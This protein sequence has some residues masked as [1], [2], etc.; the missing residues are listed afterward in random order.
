MNQ[1]RRMTDREMEETRYKIVSSL[2][3]WPGAS[4]NSLPDVMGLVQV[5]GHHVEIGSL[6]GASALAAAWSKSLGG[7]EGDIYCIDP[8]V[9]DEHEYCVRAEGNKSQKLLL[10]NQKQLFLDN[11]KKFPNIK[12]IQARSDPWPLDENLE[13]AT[14]FIDGWHY[15]EG[16]ITD[17]RNAVARAKKAVMLDDI[18]PEYVDVYKAFKWLCAES[19]WFIST[20]GYRTACFVPM[21]KKGVY[22][23]RGYVDAEVELETD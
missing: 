13:I 23:E 4:G 19:G 3:G 14:I 5:D 10:A 16:P 15:G 21:P 1:K 12:L 20:R 7:W 22:T 2:I 9:F 11:T 17:A 8:M 6:F 18:V